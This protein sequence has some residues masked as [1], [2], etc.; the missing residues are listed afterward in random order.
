MARLLFVCSGNTCRSPLAA[1]QARAIAAEHAH[2]LEA[3]V[4]DQDVTP[5]GVF[6]VHWVNVLSEEDEV[7]AELILR[8]FE[9]FIRRIFE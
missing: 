5:D 1:V 8:R 2:D 9:W 4:L 3:D 6:Y 7:V